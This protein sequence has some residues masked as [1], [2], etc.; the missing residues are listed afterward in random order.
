MKF[1]AV[2]LALAVAVAGQ[3]NT[4]SGAA[5]TT[6]AGIPACVLTCSTQAS[7]IAGCSFIDPTCSCE[8]QQFQSAANACIGANCSAA[9]AAAGLQLQN[10]TC[11]ALASALPVSGSVVAGGNSTGSSSVAAG[12]SSS[13]SSS[14]SAGSS[15]APAAT[16]T[17]S[18]GMRQEVS[19]T[20]IVAAVVAV[21]GMG[22]G[23]IVVA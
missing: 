16:T 8:N 18:S 6:T 15:S 9:D 10:A 3:S 2:L 12:G 7:S 13:G 23:A 11:A 4:A 21:V 5:P 14:S 17:K 1:A 22:I 19:M 20:G